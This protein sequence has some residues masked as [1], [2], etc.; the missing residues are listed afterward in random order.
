MANYLLFGGTFD[1]VHSGHIRMALHASLAL[2]A[3][4]IFIPAKAPRWKTPLTSS[5]DRLAMLR[6]ALKHCPSGSRISEFEIQ[7]NC[8]IN[9]TIDT[10]RH[11]KSIY[12]K[13]KLYLIIGADQV[14]QFGNW[15]SAEE[16]AKSVQIVFISRSDVELNKDVIATY[17]ML[18]L[19][20]Y[21]SGDVSST[22]IRNLESIDT[23]FEVIHYIEE[24]RLYF[25]EKLA[26]MLDEHRLNHSIEVANLALDIAK[27]N[28]LN[29]PEKYYI[30]ALLHDLGKR[31]TGLKKICFQ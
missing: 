18:D 25:I 26:K 10:V 22:K 7:R 28:H 24:H 20:Y 1:P 6:L 29:N 21:E 27:A 14:N 17:N 2:N 5:L 9:Y 12:P 16:I 4:V 31:F 23:P 3:D 11:Y 19:H 13:D 30:A 8:D 15:K